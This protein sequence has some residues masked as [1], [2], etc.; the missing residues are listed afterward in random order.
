M[1]GPLRWGV[2]GLGTIAWTT[3]G[4]ALRDD[5]DCELVACVSRE[6][7]RAQKFADRY[8]ARVAT[9]SYAEML[10]HP[11][12]DAVL[13][14]T[15]NALHAHQVI[16]AAEAG[17]HVLCDK[18]LATSVE[19]ARRQLAACEAAGVQ[20][21]IVFHNRYL[22]WVRDVRRLLAEGVIGDVL[23]VQLEASAGHWPPEGWRND[24]SLAGLGTVYNQGVHVYDALRYLL[25]AE[26]VAVSA[27]F[28][29]EGGRY[30]I[31]T[32]ALTLMRFD[33][34]VL[35]SVNS[36]ERN[37]HPQNDI[38][39]FGTAGRIIGRNLTR[40]REDGEL[41]VLTPDGET[42]TPYPSPG[43]HRLLLSAY[44][45]GVLAGEPVTPD[46]D[47][48]LRSMLLCDAIARSAREGVTARL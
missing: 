31:E 28:D 16:A 9:T 41:H 47:D 17:K 45:R 48:G 13:V 10:A 11:E 32:T 7:G 24:P 33:N 22:Q 30:A 38:A 26:P 2:I 43:A 42:V 8:G 12:V 18:P 23:T 35:A 21:G 29:D 25:D 6:Q 3:M 20:L 27:M 14:A 1:S 19:D 36:N 34:G 44:A 37:P 5:P 39:I 15:P 40:S 4:P 46:G